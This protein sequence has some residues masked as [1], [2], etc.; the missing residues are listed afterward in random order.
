MGR[1][2]DTG[3]HHDVHGSNDV[4]K[5]FFL[6]VNTVMASNYYI[7][8][9][10]L[11]VVGWNKWGGTWHDDSW[12]Q[13]GDFAKA[14]RAIKIRGDSGAFNPDDY[15]SGIDI[16]FILLNEQFVVGLSRLRAEF[17]GIPWGLFGSFLNESNHL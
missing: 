7:L 10:F 6:Q 2:V 12:S 1:G 8:G 16:Y 15:A 14:R 3:L 4:Q 9:Y 11:D 5:G 13:L 17:I